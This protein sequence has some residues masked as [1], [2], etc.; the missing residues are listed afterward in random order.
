MEFVAGAPAIDD[1][2]AF[3]QANLRP[4]VQESLKDENNL[5]PVFYNVVSNAKLD[6]LLN[7]RPVNL[8][9]L[10]MLNRFLNPELK[11]GF[12][13]LIFRMMHT[14]TK[15]QE[16]LA[17]LD[18]SATTHLCFQKGAL[19]STGNRS[20]DE[21]LHACHEFRMA[22]Y[23]TYG[24]RTNLRRFTIP[25]MVCSSA[26]GHSVN[27]AQMYAENQFATDFEQD[28][29]PGLFFYYKYVFK[30][31][32][33]IHAQ[34]KLSEDDL[35][36]LHKH[37][38]SS[39]KNATDDV[40]RAQVRGMLDSYMPKHKYITVLVFTGG[41]L[42]GLGVDDQEIA[43]EAFKY[44]GSVAARYKI[45]DREAAELKKRRKA[46]FRSMDKDDFMEEIRIN[47]M[48]PFSKEARKKIDKLSFENEEERKAHIKQILTE[49]RENKKKKGQKQRKRVKTN[50]PVSA[51]SAEA[52]DDIAGFTGEDLDEF[53]DILED[54]LTEGAGNE[55]DYGSDSSGQN[56]SSSG[57]GNSPDHGSGPTELS[58]GSAE[59]GDF[60]GHEEG[61]EGDTLLGQDFSMMD[62]LLKSAEDG[63]NS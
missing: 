43:E 39:S 18:E 29:F 46:Q 45:S 2:V 26:L 62:S 33:G 6:P 48:Q 1:P 31:R 20:R 13:A 28:L 41:K 21:A 22:L 50:A 36:Q 61:A 56:N 40:I 53:A 17:G 37:S 51:A 25:N 42:V 23:M 38:S 24:I 30:K 16:R 44:V 52:D 60:G 5:I 27:L 19:G 3:M 15:D 34:V 35:V 9:I 54:L 57:D 11:Q 8:P 10:D 63:R 49:E 47:Y 7:G 32:E 4:I 58:T 14:L 12:G 59:T 55:D